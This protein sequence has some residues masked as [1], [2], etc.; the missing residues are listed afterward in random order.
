MSDTNMETT[1]ETAPVKDDSSWLGLA[2]N[3]AITLVTVIAVLMAYHYLVAVPS[4][5]K[6]AVIDIA[7]VLSLKQLEVTV[8]ASKP[9]LTD[10]QRGESFEMIGKFAKEMEATIAEMQQECGCLLL[11][12]AAVVKAAS[13]EDMTPALKQRLGMDTLDQAQLLKQVQSLGGSGQP[14]LLDDKSK[15]T[16]Q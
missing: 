6:I 10:A 2:L 3:G 7:D 13:S 15:G 12:K 9:G 4:K 11:V 8:A 14:P 5:Q 16:G 1:P